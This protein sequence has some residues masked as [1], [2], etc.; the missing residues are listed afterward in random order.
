MWGGILD[1]N[2]ASQRAT[3]A[4]GFRPILRVT[5]VHEPQAT[6]L[7]VRPADYAD[8]RL[9]ERARGLFGGELA[10]RPTTEHAVTGWQQSNESEVQAWRA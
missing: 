10:C 2:R 9:I 1:G 5:A 4:A 8:E 7:R 3:A 6:R